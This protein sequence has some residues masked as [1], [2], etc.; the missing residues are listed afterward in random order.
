MDFETVTPTSD[1]NLIVARYD[2]AH[3]AAI[4]A[5]RQRVEA[6]AV[7]DAAWAIELKRRAMIEPMRAANARL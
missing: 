2:A 1:L 5:H 7:D 4:E 6:R 3:E